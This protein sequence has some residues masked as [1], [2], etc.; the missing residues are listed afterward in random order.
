[1]AAAVL[2]TYKFIRSLWSTEAIAQQILKKSPAL[3]LVPK[4]TNFGEEHKYITVGTSPPQGIAG[5]FLDAK[6]GKT[7]STAKEFTVDTTSYYGTFSIE[8]K[9]WR[10]YE[11]TGNKGLI[12]DPMARESKGLMEQI[13]NDLSSFLH[14]N[15]GGALGRIL[16]TSTLAS[17]TITLDTSADRRRIVKGMK[18]VASTANG[19]SGSILPGYVTVASVGGTKAAPTITI[20]EA[21]WSG[22]IAGITTTSYLFRKGATGTGSGGSGVI[23][24]FDAWCPS[25]SGSPAAFLGVTRS[26]FPEQLAGISMSATTKSPRQRIMDASMELED[27]PAPDGK[28]AYLINPLSWGKLFNELASNNALVQTKAPAAKI[29]S[30][31]TGVTYDSISVMGAGGPIDV[32]VDAWAPASVERLLTLDTWCLAS[33][34][35]LIHWDKGAMV[36]SPM[37][38]DA[39]D[40]REVRAVGDMALFC[41]NPWANVRVAVTA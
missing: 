7:A 3:G 15:G 33:T 28:L 8:G 9:L 29:G 38:E 4:E 34:G 12:L 41:R 21:T 35:E 20:E 39:A 16:S 27:G 5:G 18:L 19:T 36:D 17:Q 32:V 13:R 1:M 30:L 31:N 11:F 26:D 10:R 40:A 24:G 2:S 14:G 23:Y 6:E 25:H 37:L 22:A